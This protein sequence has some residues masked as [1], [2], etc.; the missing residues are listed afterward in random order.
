MN[1]FRKSDLRTGMILETD[2][3][4]RCVVLLNTENGNV[5]CGH[6]YMLLDNLDENLV[7]INT[8]PIMKIWQPNCNMATSEAIIDKNC[9]MNHPWYKLLFER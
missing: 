9:D 5:A 3:G 8:G 7:S 4:E 1:N 6:T 2:T